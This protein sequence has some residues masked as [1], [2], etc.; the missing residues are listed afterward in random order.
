M[1]RQDNR[2]NKRVPAHVCVCVNHVKTADL[3]TNKDTLVIVYSY[4][5]DVTNYRMTGKDVDNLL[6]FNSV[7]TFIIRCKK[8][9]K[10]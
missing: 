10:L 6:E 2:L 4:Q 1:Q 9:S 7:I 8:T 5:Q 3:E